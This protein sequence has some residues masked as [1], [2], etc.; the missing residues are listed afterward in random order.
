MALRPFRKDESASDLA[1][2][3]ICLSCFYAIRFYPLPLLLFLRTPIHL[4]LFILHASNPAIQMTMSATFH[5]PAQTA[6]P[7]T[8]FDIAYHHSLHVSG[9]RCAGIVIEESEWGRGSV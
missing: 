4:R 9:V 5:S 1:P 8:A 7:L 2:M 3:S 6:A